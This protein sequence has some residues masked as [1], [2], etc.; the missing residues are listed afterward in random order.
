MESCAWSPD[1][2]RIVSGDDGGRLIVW[3]AQSGKSLYIIGLVKPGITGVGGH[4]TW[5]PHE[6]RILEASGE[7]WRCIV[8]RGEWEDGSFENLPLD[9]FGIVPQPKTKIE[10]NMRN[11]EPNLK[12]GVA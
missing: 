12:E 8:W 4:A 5:F 2:A 1:G 3:D 11:P 6:N 7:A 10:H 9:A